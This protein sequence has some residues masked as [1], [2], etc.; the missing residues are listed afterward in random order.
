[1][2]RAT[3]GCRRMKYVAPE[4]ANHLIDRRRGDAEMSLHLG[5]GGSLTEHALIDIDEGQVVALRSGEA[6]RADT[7]RRA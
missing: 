6:M 1:M 7:A 3:P 4:A 5:F 2:L